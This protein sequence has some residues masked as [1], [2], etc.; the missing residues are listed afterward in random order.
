VTQV[1]VFLLL[2]LTSPDR[3]TFESCRTA[4]GKYQPNNLCRDRCDLD[5]DGD[6]D[7]DD[8]GLLQRA[9]YVP[10]SQ[11]TTQPTTQPCE[12]PCS[13]DAK[14][15]GVDITWQVWRVLPADL[16]AE[17][18]TFNQQFGAKLATRPE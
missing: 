18:D 12:C 1:L 9:W 15:P 17:F 2:L 4:P 6:V 8:W 3:Q 10:A 11:P 14:R 7:L 13:P 5:R 16:Q